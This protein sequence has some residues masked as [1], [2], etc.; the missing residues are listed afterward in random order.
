[1]ILPPRGV[2]LLGFVPE[3]K[4]EQIFY[5]ATVLPSHKSYQITFT[6]MLEYNLKRNKDIMIY[7]KYEI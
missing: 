4:N 3:N 5:L 1:M 2:N 6:N 7:Y